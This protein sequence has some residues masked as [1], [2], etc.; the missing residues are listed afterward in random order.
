MR[1]IVFVVTLVTAVLGA[2]VSAFAQF[3]PP[4]P[5]DDRPQRGLF[6]SSYANTEQR[7][8]LDTSFGGGYDNDLLGQATGAP[9]P[10]GG[11]R[12]V[13]RFGFAAASLGYSMNREP[14][15][16]SAYLG[17]TGHYYPEMDNPR[18]FA[19]GAG[20]QASWQIARRTALST[21]N[22][23]NSQPYSLR[24]FYGLPIDPET[25][26]DTTDVLNYAIGSK[27]YVDWRSSVGVSVARSIV[28]R[29]SAGEA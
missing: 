8:I 10:S 12:G 1:R 27:S 15:S 14:I 23:L 26:P 16:A 13:G 17:G 6:G 22:Q 5:R 9:T 4:R 3:Q 2:A 20:M 7:L 24:A 19:L 25:P 29:S 28:S 18:V 21:S 11:P